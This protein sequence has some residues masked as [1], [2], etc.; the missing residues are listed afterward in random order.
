MTFVVY[1]HVVLG[2]MVPKNL[3]LAGPER[4]AMVLGPPMVALVAVLK[5]IVYG[6]DALANG[7]V[8]LLKVEPRNDVISTFTLKEVEAMVDESHDEGMLDHSEY[9][10]LAGALGFTSRTVMDVLLSLSQPETV[11]RGARASDVE[12][13]CANAGYSRFPVVG[14][15]GELVGYLHIKDVLQAD[16]HGRA[17]MVEEKWIRPFAGVRDTDTWSTPS[18][19]CRPRG[20]H[21]SRRRRGLDRAR[22]DRARGRDRGAGRR[23]PGRCPRR[24]SLSRGSG[25]LGYWSP[26]GGGQAEHDARP[27]LAQRRSRSDPATMALDDPLAHREADSVS[28]VHSALVARWKAS[29]ILVALFG[30][31]PMPSSAT[32]T[33]A[34]LVDTPAG[35]GH[36]SRLAGYDVL[37]RVADQVVQEPP[38][39]ARRRT[40]RGA[41]PISTY[42][43]VTRHLG[44]MLGDRTGQRLEVD[45]GGAELLVARGRRL[46]QVLD[47]PA[48]PLGAGADPVHLGRLHPAWSGSAVVGQVA[49][50][51]LR[52]PV[53]HGEGP[54][55]SCATTLAKDSSSDRCARSVVTSW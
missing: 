4:A 44:T 1:L 46:E 50:E 48:H 52:P 51:H 32:V 47:Q 23:D 24:R 42:G 5:P 35:D 49:R 16:P 43:G 33:S 9:E 30:R 41:Q 19:R 21:G 22:H 10:R 17:R 34:M 45:H 27:A 25:Y 3:A 54:S 6:L 12:V 28:V 36:L 2:E 31:V 40:P 15:D 29:N 8:R 39:H 37:D 18:R 14:D 13:I 38:D 20:P 53:D 7:F 26:R 55:R 11:E